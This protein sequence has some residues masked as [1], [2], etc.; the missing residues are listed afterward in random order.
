MHT[1]ELVA[2]AGD[3]ERIQIKQLEKEVQHLKEKVRKGG[4]EGEGG[5]EG[6]KEGGRGGRREGGGWE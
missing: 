3:V 5:R 2:I 4:R 1:A 6:G